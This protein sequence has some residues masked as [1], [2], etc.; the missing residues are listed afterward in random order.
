MVG[1]NANTYSPFQNLAY[2]DEDG[3]VHSVNQVLKSL[4]GAPHLLGATAP[5]M[6]GTNANTYSPFQNLGWAGEDGKPIDID[7]VM[8]AHVEKKNS[9]LEDLAR[10]AM[11]R[12]MLSGLSPKLQNLA[13][14]DQ[15][16]TYHSV[17]KGM[18]GGAHLLG[19]TA[20]PIMVGANSNTWAPVNII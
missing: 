8:E 7:A 9:P 16:G 12:Y 14:L 4:D 2:L 15:D 1:T 19:A 18:R 17:A 13:Y 3:Q 10:I 6:V 5:V 11:L 20:A